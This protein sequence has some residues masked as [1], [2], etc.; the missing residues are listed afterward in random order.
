[1]LFV[2]LSSLHLFSQS[3]SSEVIANSGDNF[4]GESATLSWTLGESA[5][6]VLISQPFIHTQGFHQ[7]YLNT[8][9]NAS[10]ILQ[11]SISVYPNP[12]REHVNISFKNINT[13][14]K[15]ELYDLA[16]K[17]YFSKN[18]PTL[19]TY[20]LDIN[21]YADGKYLLQITTSQNKI[22]GIIKSSK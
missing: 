22:F 13:E 8:K 17:K 15:L 18:I 16:G 21:K 20:Q 10:E 7:T 2:M 12:A 4:V 6:D 11:A 9:T 14:A 3:I 1:M 5:A 19:E